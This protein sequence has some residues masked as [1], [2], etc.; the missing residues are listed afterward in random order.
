M[1][2]NLLHIKEY[3]PIILHQCMNLI[4]ALLVAGA[5]TATPVL[6]QDDEVLKPVSR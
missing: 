4:N 1:I 3:G 2:L 5:L 6:A